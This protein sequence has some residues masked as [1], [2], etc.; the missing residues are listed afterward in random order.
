MLNGIAK[1]FNGKIHSIARVAVYSE[2][3]KNISIRMPFTHGQ[4]LISMARKL[5]GQFHIRKAE[6]ELAGLSLSNVFLA[7]A[8]LVDGSFSWHVSLNGK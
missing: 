4:C 5:C 7:D 1:D 6:A 2:T 8:R 3:G